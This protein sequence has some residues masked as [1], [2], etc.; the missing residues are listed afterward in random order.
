MIA[1][2]CPG[3]DPP[4][5]GYFVLSGPGLS[6]FRQACSHR[7]IHV[8]N[9]IGQPTV[10]TRSISLKKD[11]EEVFALFARRP[12]CFYLDSALSNSELSR[13]S[14]IGSDPFYAIKSRG[15]VMDIVEGKTV[16]HLKGDPLLALQT[17]LQRFQVPAGSPFVP[18]IG[19]AVGYLAYEM[20]RLTL[21][22]AL[23]A[24]DDLGLPEMNLN[25]YRKLLAYEH[26]TNRW[27]AAAADFSGGRGASIRKRLG[28]DIEKLAA[29]AD[30]S[31]AEPAPAPAPPREVSETP[32]A[33][34][35]EPGAEDD[36]HPAAESEV[37]T[38]GPYP[39]ASSLSREQ[40]L[41]RAEQIRNRISGG[42]ITD[43][44]L[45]QRL[46]AS[47][48]GNPVDLYLALRRIKPGPYGCYLDLGDCI[49]AGQSPELFLSV[50]GRTVESRPA[51]RARSRGASNA[52]DPGAAGVPGP[53]GTDEDGMA[54]IAGVSRDA[55]ARV[56]RP[57]SVELR[58]TTRLDTYPDVQHLVAH[59]R[60]EMASGLSMVDLLRAVFPGASTTG[61]PRKRA[62]E[63]LDEVEPVARGP[64]TGAM[65]L[66]GLDGTV[67]LNV[68][69]RTFIIR[70]EDVYFGVG[71]TITADSDPAAVY[72][73][74]LARARGLLEALA[75]AGRR[76]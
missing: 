14:Y 37:I 64:Y 33:A 55:L 59:I 29:L 8:T 76:E 66:I 45:T 62:M 46:R 24:H 71:G 28:V 17:A 72:Q 39:F 31:G 75:V 34:P 68:A 40:Y 20:G 10:L 21:G 35:A 42:E 7:E 69:I 74:S 57:G 6:P 4:E 13:F 49:L 47:F 12:G 61:A 73:E 50:R 36:L 27:F 51:L 65:G 67:D 41:E 60:G 16:R 48:H 53:A 5:R 19:G 1:I 3:G 54:R 15:L 58:E 44:V 23:R 52:V 26:A 22:T 2:A 32:D 43:A 9:V 63:I 11:P 30:G 38:D 25:F 18:F 56:C 70:G